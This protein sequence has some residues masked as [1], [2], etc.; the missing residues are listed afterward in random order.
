MHKF[1]IKGTREACWK[2]MALSDK[3]DLI[4]RVKIFEEDFCS[5]RIAKEVADADKIAKRNISFIS[6]SASDYS[7]RRRFHTTKRASGLSQ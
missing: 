3:K 1:S 7:D 6:K 5:E 4:A 2:V